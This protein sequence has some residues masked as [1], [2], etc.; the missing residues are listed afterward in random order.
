MKRK[1]QGKKAVNKEVGG[2]KVRT[3]LRQGE[4]K[5]SLFELSTAEGARGER[6]R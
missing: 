1:E 6:E 2:G 5:N 4:K 3:D